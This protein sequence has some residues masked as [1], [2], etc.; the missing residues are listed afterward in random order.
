[1]T[2][3]KEQPKV[4]NQQIP[5]NRAFFRSIENSFLTHREM[6]GEQSALFFLSKLME[7][8]LS[9]AYIV[10]GVKENGG[11]EQFRRKRCSCR[12]EC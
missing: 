8:S 12:P 5:Y 1:V 7:R 9:E 10:M 11:V 2:K 4:Q 6:F 3:Q